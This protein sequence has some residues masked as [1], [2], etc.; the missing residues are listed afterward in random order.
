MCCKDRFVSGVFSDCLAAVCE[1]VII[2]LPGCHHHI[3]INRE[4]GQER[5]QSC[6]ASDTTQDMGLI[7]VN[8]LLL[9]ESL[10][11]D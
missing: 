8:L 3:I 10:D 1:A 9:S 7:Q 6:S 2:N 5:D 4:D 11:K